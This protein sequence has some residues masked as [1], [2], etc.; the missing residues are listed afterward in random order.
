[1]FFPENIVKSF[2]NIGAE[3]SEI[4]L[5]L[6]ILS[7]KGVSRLSTLYFN[8]ISGRKTESEGETLI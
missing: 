3:M 8:F 6:P 5:Q 2:Q 4:S 1:M 7:Q